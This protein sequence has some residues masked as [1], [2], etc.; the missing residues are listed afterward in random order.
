MGYLSRQKVVQTGLQV[1]TAASAIN[2][3]VIKKVRTHN[4]AKWDYIP[5]RQILQVPQRPRL[6]QS[7]H[8][9]SSDRLPCTCPLILPVLR[10]LSVQ[11]ALKNSSIKANEMWRC[12][13]SKIGSMFRYVFVQQWLRQGR[14]FCPLCL[15]SLKGKIQHICAERWEEHLKTECLCYTVTPCSQLIMRQNTQ[16]SQMDLGTWTVAAAGCFF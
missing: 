13:D 7:S 12:C 5:P 2:T 8:W 4:H 1:D 6:C 15:F 3:V 16:H 11:E 9:A 14:L 10:Q